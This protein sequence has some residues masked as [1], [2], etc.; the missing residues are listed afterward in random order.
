MREDI[1]K[2]ITQELLKQRGKLI[3]EISKLDYNTTN[4]EDKKFEYQNQ[5][6]NIDNQVLNLLN[7]LGTESI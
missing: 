1:V 2:Q 5:I 4:S 3:K 7:S 6:L